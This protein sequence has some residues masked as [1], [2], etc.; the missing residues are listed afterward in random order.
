MAGASS[1]RIRKTR[2]F[3][4]HVNITPTTRKPVADFPGCSRSSATCVCPIILRYTEGPLV[5]CLIARACTSVSTPDRTLV[6]HADFP[7]DPWSSGLVGNS[8]EQD[9][10]LGRG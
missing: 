6:P 8:P 7:A 2:F 4:T 10:V 9:L 3:M 1:R 5:Y